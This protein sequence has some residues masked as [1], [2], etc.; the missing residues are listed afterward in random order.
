MGLEMWRWT[1]IDSM[2]VY[3][4][5]WLVVGLGIPF[6]QPIPGSGV[7]WQLIKVWFNFS[8]QPKH[9]VSSRKLPMQWIV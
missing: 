5:P 8:G 4:L 7:H 2:V 3:H 6:F 9:L 1:W